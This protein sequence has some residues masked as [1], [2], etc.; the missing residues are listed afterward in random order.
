M[1]R[2]PHMFDKDQPSESP[3]Q[4]GRMQEINPPVP[5]FD[6]GGPRPSAIERTGDDGAREAPQRTPAERKGRHNDRTD[7]QADATMPPGEGRDPKRN[8]L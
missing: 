6:E 7:K 2:K 5:S 3:G 1:D 8:T 4:R